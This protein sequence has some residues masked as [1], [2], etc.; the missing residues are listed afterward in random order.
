MKTF[1]KLLGWGIGVVLFVVIALAVSLPFLFDANDFKD[2]ITAQVGQETGLELTIGGDINFSFLPWLGMQLEDV[3]LGNAP[4]YSQETFAQAEQIAVQVK[5]LPLL[6]SKIELDTITVQ[7]L[8]LNLERNQAGQGNWEMLMAQPAEQPTR[9]PSESS[10]EVSLNQLSINGLDIRDAQILWDDRSAGQRYRIKEFDLETSAIQFGQ[11]FNIDSQLQLISADPPLAAALALT[12]EVNFVADTQILTLRDFQLTSDIQTEEPLVAAAFELS[13]ENTTLDLSNQALL[14]Q[15]LEFAINDLKAPST[16][17]EGG[18][19][20]LKGVLEGDGNLYRISTLKLIADLQGD[21]LP[22]GNF[23]LDLTANTKVNLEKQTLVIDK[24]QINTLDLQ[25]A[26]HV[27]GQ[28]LAA[29]P[30]FSGALQTKPFNPRQLLIRLGQ[31][32]PKTADANALTKGA[33][34]TKFAVSPGSVTLDP[35]KVQLDDS[36]LT[37]NLSISDLQGPNIRFKIAI[38]TLNL[39]RYL[40][41]S[42]EETTHTSENSSSSSPTVEGVTLDPLR[43]LD[44]AGELRIG[45]LSAA[46]LKTRDI[47][48][49]ITVKQSILTMQPITAKLYQGTL[50]S[51]IELDAS[52]KQ[53]RMTLD[54]VLTGIQAGPL[55]KDLVGKDRLTGT[56]QLNS[57]LSWQG[58]DAVA[59]KSSLNGVSRFTFRDG[60]IKGINL[61]LLIRQAK[62]AITGQPLAPEHQGVAQTDFSELSGSVQLTNG[63]AKNNDLL[64]KSPLLRITGQGVANLVQEKLDYR[65]TT[66]VVSTTRGQGGEDLAQLKGIP[67]PIKVTGP[68]TEP[69]YALD[70]A[71]L[72]KAQTEI[73]VKE[74]QDQLKQ[75][76]Q[77][78]LQKQ[79]EKLKQPKGTQAPERN[80]QDLQD[81]AR[82]ALKKLF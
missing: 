46:K 23:D 14:A 28:N 77:G 39:D 78:L 75:Q 54:N 18:E 24:L 12:G 63:L 7:G 32:A 50:Q 64:A 47:R 44:L 5:L 17:V 25:L 6:Q 76:G 10:Q 71:A 66:T 42:G 49:P 29:K 53:P 74:K 33:M 21:G 40:P 31:T 26:G 58:L 70:V 51:G 67:I 11:P 22:G 35:I 61:G 62:A 27:M 37:G 1:L 4:N 43:Q 80:D 82:D 2:D 36:Q 9:Q 73:L 79:L 60:A 41:A 57:Q 20:V 8:L 72:L 19:I 30:Q 69:R 81:K 16:G 68:L 48:L 34:R 45:Q 13:T 52:S 55:L 38:D 65:L 56:A 3:Q 59:I 15:D